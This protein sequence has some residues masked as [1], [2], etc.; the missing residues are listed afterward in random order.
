MNLRQLQLLLQ[1]VDCNLNVSAAARASHTTQPSVSRHLQALEKRLG[2]RIFVR[3]R[4]RITGLTGV[5]RQVVDSA[6]RVMHAAK[7]LEALG[8]HTGRQ[9]RGTITIAASHTYAR[10]SL[11]HIVCAFM[12]RHPK[13][14]LV[15]RQG[16]PQQIMA[17]ASSGEADV[18]ICAE[19]N[20]RSKDL[21]FFSCN[22][23]DRV[24]LVPP[25]H[26]LARMKRPTLK[27]LSAYPLITYDA[28]FAIH[29]KI[30]EA[31]EA[32]ALMPNIVLTATDVDVMK[33]YVKCGMG[34]AVVASL[35]YSPAEDREL[36]AIAANH[37]FEPT[38]IKLGVRKAAF[39]APF[40]YDFIE[41]FSPSLKREHIE[42]ALLA[43]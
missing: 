6:R 19:P 28:Q 43:P 30:L 15:L 42:A 13:V 29:R 8:R 27:Q 5:G 24:I 21:V 37:L 12:R 16:D 20:G 11:P 14:R 41:A 40:V 34:V 23:H 7:S 39:L 10:Y 32:H 36:Q 4:R 2:I 38:T 26:P 17:W 22:R 9:Q 18:A 3:S 35:A 31:F 33:T 1:V 25:G